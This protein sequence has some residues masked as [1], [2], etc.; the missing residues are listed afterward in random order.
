MGDPTGGKDSITDYTAHVTFHFQ[1]IINDSFDITTDTTIVTDVVGTRTRP[2]QADFP[3]VFFHAEDIDRL[4]SP[5]ALLDDICLNGCAALLHYE[6]DPTPG[7]FAVLSTYTLQLIRRDASDDELWRNTKRTKY[8]E[9]SVWILPIHRPAS[10]HWVMCRIDF[11]AM[12]IDLFDSFA[13][14][15]PWRTEIKVCFSPRMMPNG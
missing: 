12:R 6:F 3:S 11:M 7:R 8:W 5:T 15:N 10:C 4:V 13:E 2:A 9:K 14:L 1:E